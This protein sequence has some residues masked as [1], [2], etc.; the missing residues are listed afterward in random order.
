M[1]RGGVI[2]YWPERSQGPREAKMVDI[3]PKGMRMVCG[4]KIR[5]GT[6]LRIT[7]PGFKASGRVK[8][9]G[10]EKGAGE[11]LYALSVSFP[12]IEF[13]VSRG[14]FLSATA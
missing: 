13:E 4:Q 7:G 14:V 8:D 1:K 2:H 9:S 3:S 11:K 6:I 10:V 5:A 12:D